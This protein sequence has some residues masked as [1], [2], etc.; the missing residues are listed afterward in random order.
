MKK[1]IV[2]LFVLMLLAF[3][4]MAC[5]DK[6]YIEAY[7]FT[8]MGTIVQVQIYE[9]NQEAFTAVED[10]FSLYSQITSSYNRN[11]V[12]RGHKYHGYNNIFLINQNAG[13]EPVKVIEELIEVLELGLELHTITNGY[14]NIGLGKISNIWKHFIT[15]QINH[16]KSKYLQTL[17]TVN[18]LV[19]VDLNKIQINKEKS[20]VYLTDDSIELDL[21]AIAKGYATQ[22]A[23]NYLK[24][25]LKMTKFKINAGSSSIAIGL[26]PKDHEMKTYIRDE[27]NLYEE[28][29]EGISVLGYIKAENKHIATSGS[30]EQYANVY[31]EDGTLFNKA[32]HLISPHTLEPVNNY[33]KVTLLGDDSGLLDVYATAVFL[34]NLEELEAFFVGK[35]IG[36]VLYLKDYSIKTN[37][38]EDEFVPYAKIKDK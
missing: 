17:A 37:L 38:N 8:S 31:N 1:K 29:A 11:E 15:G 6:E 28:Y 22:V 4:L 25:E 3:G 19:E 35:N 16:S 20:E 23:Y 33:Y 26:G 34:M 2:S 32:H 14:F 13:K 9:K 7:N 30:A 10:I 18:E 36:Y 5:K 12:T 21:G 24:D 27:F